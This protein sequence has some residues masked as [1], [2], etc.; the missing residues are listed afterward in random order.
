M[1]RLALLGMVL[2]VC[3]TARFPGNPKQP[4]PFRERPT[5]AP[6]THPVGAWGGG[7]PERPIQGQ[8]PETLESRIR[9]MVRREFAALRERIRRI[10][11]TELARTAPRHDEPDI[12]TALQLVT[13]KAL[14][15]TIAFLAS[16]EL[17]GR[18]AGSRGNDRA[19]E[20]IAD[21]YRKAGLVPVGDRD[22]EGEPTFF[23]TFEVDGRKTRN[24]LALLP[25]QDPELKNQVV[26]VGGHHDHLGAGDDG[27]LEQRLGQERNGDDIWNGADDNGSGCGTVTVVA[28]ALGESGLRPRRS[29]LFMTF[30]G[31]EWGLL[32]SAHYVR[33]PAFPLERHVAMIN[34]DMIGRNADRPVGV[35][36][37]GTEKGDLFEKLVER[38][39]R[40]T[41]LQY[42]PHQEPSISGGDS[43]HTSFRKMGIPV[44][45]FFTGLHRD[46][47]Q[48]TD[49]AEK[50]AYENLEK[51]GRTVAYLAWL[52]ANGD[53]RPLLARSRPFEMPDVPPRGTPGARRL[54]F[55]ADVE[56][57]VEEMDRLG[58][59]PEEGGIRVSKI[60]PDSPAEQAGLKPGDVL[61]SFAGKPFPR[62]LSKALAELR[63]RVKGVKAGETVELVVLREGT[64][65]TLQVT[66]NE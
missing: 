11:E 40:R 50:L 10:V 43:D 65:K 32:G 2:G 39:A 16:D 26:V 37:L 6:G 34:L 28:R 55:K 3:A 54:G 63:E 14:R 47:H 18:A 24:T 29:I 61:V 12:E 21:A 33:H 66:W 23:Q 48:V 22:E 8:E 46:Y 51:I 15:E 42:R 52:L 53:E 41:G 59:G 19:A 36:G 35:Y 57:T 20:Y 62:P 60:S 56:F 31:E 7:V 44:M 25:G 4:R 64:K 13:A 27:P 58:L 49:H 38:A 30:S 1:I 17:R 9:A 45:F 5:D